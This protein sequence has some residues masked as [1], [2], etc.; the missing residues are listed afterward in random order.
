VDPQYWISKPN[1]FPPIID[2]ETFDR[3]QAARPRR[4][5]SLWSN[6]EI[7]RKLRRLLAA[8]G[9]LSE[10]LIIR[11][12]G[13]PST[14]TLHRHFG[15][16]RQLYEAVGYQRPSCDMF[17]GKSAEPALRLRRQVVNKLAQIFPNHIRVMGLAPSGRSCLEMDGDS[18]VYVS[19]CLSYE[20]LSRTFWVVRPTATEP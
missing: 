15:S 6:E 10:R 5:D 8:K 12:S 14:S 18:K 4:S 13:L 19:M 9:Y 16:Y 3:A 20:R 2:R 11:A 7:L 1:A 17:H